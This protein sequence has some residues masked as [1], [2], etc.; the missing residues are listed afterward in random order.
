MFSFVKATVVS[1]AL[2]TSVLATHGNV[3]YFEAGLGACGYTNASYQYVA[4]VS[5]SRFN[6]YPGAT[7]NP[8]N[9]PICHHSVH[10]TSSVG[11]VTAQ[12]VDYFTASGIDNYVGLSSGAFEQLA[13]T[14]QGIVTDVN[15]VIV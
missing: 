6:G 9:N 15:W 8:N 11:N 2:A 4:S 10:I 1:A 3:F 12:I 14:S 5:A 7:A 13:T